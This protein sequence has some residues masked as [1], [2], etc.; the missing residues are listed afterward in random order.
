M[1]KPK[2]TLIFIGGCLCGGIRYQYEGEIGPA[3]YCHCED[4]RRSTG[5]AFNIGVRVAGSGFR[6]LQGKPKGFTKSGDRGNALTRHFCPECGSS[7]YTSSPRHPVFMYIKAGTLDNPSI[8]KP[9]H[10][11]WVQSKVPWATIEP[12]LPADAKGRS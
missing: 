11:I 1:S 12:A 3:N 10:Q 9:S 4:C 7:L 5:S 2:S 6:I 8:V